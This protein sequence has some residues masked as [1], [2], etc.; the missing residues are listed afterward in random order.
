MFSDAMNQK[1]KGQHT[2][3]TLYLSN[4]SKIR[5][6]MLTKGNSKLI[7]KIHLPGHINNCNEKTQ[8]LSTT[9]LLKLDNDRQQRPTIVQII[10]MVLNCLHCSYSNDPLSSSHSACWLSN[11]PFL[12]VKALEGSIVFQKAL[13]HGAKFS[14]R[15]I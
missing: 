1:L 6:F 9:T 11:L 5:H 8:N 15:N 13:V 2:C 12:Q 3:L 4:T 14:L 10:K 7:S